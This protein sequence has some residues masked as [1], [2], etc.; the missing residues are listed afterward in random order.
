[1]VFK[2]RMRTEGTRE[3]E[4][5]HGRPKETSVIHST[6]KPNERSPPSKGRERMIFSAI[7]QTN[8]IIFMCKKKTPRWDEALKAYNTHPL[9]C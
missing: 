9:I 8:H 3:I 5:G 1:M 4:G 2:S 6:D 7:R